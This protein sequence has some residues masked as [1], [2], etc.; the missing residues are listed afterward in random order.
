MTKE[1]QLKRLDDY[2]NWIKIDENYRIMK[3]FRFMYQDEYIQFFE[4]RKYL[5]E[6]YSGI[7]D[8]DRI[9]DNYSK[10]ILNKVERLM[11]E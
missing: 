11:N 10:I 7:E 3:E 9:I 1:E 2:I 5:I 4:T 6:K 8:Y